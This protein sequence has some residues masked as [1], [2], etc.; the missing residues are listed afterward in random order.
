MPHDPIKL[1]MTFTDVELCL[2]LSFAN[3][4]SMKALVIT[5]YT[6]YM[7]TS[8]IHSPH[9]YHHHHHEYDKDNLLTFVELFFL[10]CKTPFFSSYKICWEET[11]NIFIIY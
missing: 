8:L 10:L 4:S 6:V 7:K 11:E 1:N 5:L 9:C 3:T 2:L